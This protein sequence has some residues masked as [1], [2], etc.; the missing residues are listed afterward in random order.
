[1]KSEYRRYN[2]V[3]AS[4]PDYYTLSQVLRRHYS[5][6]LKDEQIPDII[7]IDDGK[8]K[9]A[10]AINMFSALKMCWNKDKPKLIAV[11]KAVHVSLDW[12]YYFC[13]T[14][15]VLALPS[16]SLSLH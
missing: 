6:S 2:I 3:R 7:F 13:V 8:G 1:M 5:K 4:P 16:D 15:K 10:K 12:K 9:L 14:G 11:E